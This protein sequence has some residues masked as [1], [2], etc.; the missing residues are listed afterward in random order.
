MPDAAMP[1]AALPFKEDIMSSI[2]IKDLPDSIEL[3][4]EAMRTI[5]GGS[6][7]GGRQAF[8]HRS[9]VRGSGLINAP[10]GFTHRIVPSKQG[11]SR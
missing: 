9:L 1:R 7:S 10:S 11:S 3:D 6:R 4:R 8:P 2:T 5:T